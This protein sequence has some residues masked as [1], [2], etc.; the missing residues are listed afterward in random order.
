MPRPDP[1]SS[2]PEPLS[3]VGPP[4]GVPAFVERIPT[5]PYERLNPLT[6]LVVAIVSAVIAFAIRGWTGPAVVLIATLALTVHAGILRRA[7]KALLLTTPLVLSIVVVNTIAYPGA[8]D[9]IARIGPFT[10]TE[11]GLIAALQ[12]VLRV[13]AFGLS[14][15]LFS[16]TTPT[17]D[18]LDDLER[19]GLGRR[20]V[21]VIG[22][23]IGMV[24]TMRERGAEIADSQRARGLDTEG[25]RV[26]RVLGLVPLVGPM[27]FGA[28]AEVEE[29]TQAL[30]ARGFSAP[31][32][33]TVIRRLPE[34]P[35]ESPLRYSLLLVTAV[36]VAV[37]GA[38]LVGLP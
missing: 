35:G 17:D 34:S 18:L 10:A 5:R 7:L 38:G 28:L 11:S 29:Q 23:A 6:K 33:R 3:T 30:E 37:S 26:R 12:A 21:F 9:V 36:A 25:G 8:T 16:M 13:A 14:V 22:T 32:R 31:G 19:R 20:A 27:V 2:R 1:V 4:P 24:P 15:A